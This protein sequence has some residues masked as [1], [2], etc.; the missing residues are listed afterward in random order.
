MSNHT[1]GPWTAIGKVIY[2]PSPEGGQ[3]GGAHDPA[4]AS[5][6][7]AAPDLLAA[8]EEVLN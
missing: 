4:D 7:A 1:P 2:G 8:L 5:L 6:M 3:I